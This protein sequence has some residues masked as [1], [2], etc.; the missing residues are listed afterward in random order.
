LS[1]ETIPIVIGDKN[2]RSQGI[3][4]KVLSVLVERARELGWKKLKTKGIYDYNE[5]SH[6]LYKSLG[7]KIVDYGINKNNIKYMSYELMLNN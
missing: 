5:R 3:G 4:K 7:F 2:Y 1:T 6:R